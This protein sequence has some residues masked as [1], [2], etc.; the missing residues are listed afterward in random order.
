[1]KIGSLFS[2][3]ME[4][5]GFF[6]LIVLLA[7]PIAGAQEMNLPAGVPDRVAPESDALGLG[8]GGFTAYPKL[9]V[10]TEI[11]RAHV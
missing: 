11:G 1:M 5:A 7:A 10:S 6:L 4:R 2:T 8:L 9:G 3:S